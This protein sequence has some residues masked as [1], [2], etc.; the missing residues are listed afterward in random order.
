MKISKY[1]SLNEATKSQ[2]AIRLGI[3]N[4][5]P[6]NLIDN[7]KFVAEN[8]FDK[9]R[10]Y[11]DGPLGVSSFYRCDELN[12]AIG[13]SA[14]S[15]HVK[16]EAIDIDCDMYGHSTNKEVF[17]FIRNN[18][19]FDQLIWEFGSEENPGWVHVSLSKNVNR[20]QV[21][22]AYRT[23]TGKTAYISFDLY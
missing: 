4:T 17:D 14:T 8:I 16:G 19:T 1:V 7:M 13:G 10:D 5:P 12:K 2:T 3:D 22:R 20:G 18:L 6:D 15:Q 11:I 21:L 9:V 23:E